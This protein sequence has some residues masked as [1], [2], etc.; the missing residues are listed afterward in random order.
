[1]KNLVMFAAATALVFLVAGCQDQQGALSDEHNYIT[2]KQPI[3]L[4]SIN[5]GEVPSI[6]PHLSPEDNVQDSITVIRLSKDKPPVTRTVYGTTSSTILGSP[7]TAIVGRYGIVT[8]HDDRS[9]LKVPPEA[10]G[11]NQ[12]VAIDLESDDLR[13]VSRVELARQPWLALAHPDGKRVIVALSDHWGVYKVKDDGALVEVLQSASPGIVYSFDISND[14]RTIIA[15]I[16]KG[17]DPLSSKAGIFHFVINE[18]SRIDLVGE[19]TSD[20]FKIDGPFSPRISPDGKR[21]LVL[22]SEGGSDG[23]LD[24]VLVLDLT[25]DVKISQSIKQVADGLESLAIHPSGEFAVVTC[26]D[27]HG[28]TVTSHLAIVDLRGDEVQLLHH[29]PIELVPEGIEF[30]PDGTKLFVGST[31]A[32]H[33]VVYD[34]RGMNLYRS[35]YVLPTGYGHSAL[36]LRAN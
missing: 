19:I 17:L 34:V 15:T 30:T 4:F 21:A 24:D 6:L 16:A 10:I 23:V 35:P 33:V 1:M 20:K 14:G 22:N 3:I 25:G 12:I 27:M 26:L 28:R 13:V 29:I 2:T 11:Q 36:A 5:D 18:D 7:R 8:N 32:N 31:R 9:G